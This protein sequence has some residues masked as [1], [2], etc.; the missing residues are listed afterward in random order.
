MATPIYKAFYVRTTEAWYQLPPEEQAVLLKKV[1]EARTEVGGKTII[2]CDSGW[3]SEEW[4]TFGVEVY[5]DIE[6]VQRH[7]ELLAE[8]NW[9]RYIESRTLLGVTTP[10]SVV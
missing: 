1:D 10:F 2:L 4:T 5:P 8:I 6:A 3:S 9:Y 7:S